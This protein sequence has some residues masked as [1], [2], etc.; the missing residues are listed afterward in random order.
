MMSSL[1]ISTS[2]LVAQR[3]RLNAISGNIANIS[4]LVDENGNPSPYK[5]RQVVFQTDESTGSGEAAGVKV[6]EVMIDQS[7]PLYRYQPDH[8]L[9]IKEGEWEGY[10]AYPNI[11]LTT[12]M[13]DAMETTRAYEAN[14]GVIE[15]SKDMSR[16]RLAILA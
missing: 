16:Q 1:D 4:S 10:V 3:T 9:A 15:I 8:P 6:S 12:Q 13:V 7:E 2:A 14:I 5:A 11:D